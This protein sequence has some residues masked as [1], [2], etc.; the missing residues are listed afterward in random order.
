M[1]QSKQEHYLTTQV[2]SASPHKLIEM[3]LEAAIKNTRLSQRDIE[4]G[5]TQKASDHLIR[6]QEIINELR[7]SINEEVDP[8]LSES[9]VKLYDF[10]YQRLVTANIKKEIEIVNEVQHLLKE[11][12]ETWREISSS[13]S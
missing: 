12:L 8:I 5:Q 1:Y 2:M 9:L 4:K 6:A 7:Y 13:D 11:L 3:L 10:M